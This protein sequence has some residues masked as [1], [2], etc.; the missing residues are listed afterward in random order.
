MV[1]QPYQSKNRDYILQLA[2]RLVRAT[3]TKE[4]AAVISEAYLF[5]SKQEWNCFM[6]ECWRLKDECKRRESFD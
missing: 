3:T 2:Q 1:S 4:F 5:L 6:A